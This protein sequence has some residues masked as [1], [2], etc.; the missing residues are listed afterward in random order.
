MTLGSGTSA[1]SCTGTASSSG[2]ASCTIATV[3]QTAGSVPTTASF[4]GNGYLPRGGHVVH[5][6]GRQPG[7]DVVPRRSAEPLH[8]AT[9]RERGR[10]R[11]VRADRGRGLR[12]HHPGLVPAHRGGG[13]QR[14]P[15]ADGLLRQQVDPDPGLHRDPDAQREPTRRRSPAPKAGYRAATSRSLPPT[16][17]ATRCPICATGGRSTSASPAR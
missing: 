16:R 15:A 11:H 17:A 14:L 3:S 4:A 8:R 12:L 9:G 10:D 2:A 7:P 13:G 6:V 1:Q 5:C